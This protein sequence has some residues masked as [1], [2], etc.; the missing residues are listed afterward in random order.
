MPA[1]LTL[2]CAKRVCVSRSLWPLLSVGLFAINPLL[3]ALAEAS[4]TEDSTLT[5]GTVTVQGATDSNGPLSTSS[6][7]SSVDVLGADILEKM[8]VN[9]SWE[10]FSRAPGVMLTEFNQG[11]TS[12]KISF[13]GF[14]GEGEVNA[15]KL[16]IDGI[17][18]N[19]NDGNMPFMDMIF[20]MELDS[21]EVVRGTSDA[22]YGLN[23]IAGNVN[24]L[25]RTGGDYTKARIRYG[26]YN[27]QETQLAKGIETSNWT[28]N[29][30][31]AYQ[32]SD[33]YR[34]HAQADKFSMAGKW[35]Y[36]PD[37]NRY[38]IGLIA[39][40]YETEAQEPGYLSEEDAHQHPTMTN[41]Y[42][43]T[44]KGTRRMNQL[45]VHF[46]T[47]LSDTL[48]WAAKTYVNTF[49]DRRWTQYWRTS[50][51]QERDAYETQYGALTSLTWRP[52]V[53]WLY[54]FALEGGA[55][56]QQQHNKSERYR[57]KDRVRQAQ[58]R[59][60]QFDFDTYGAYVQ[61]EIK[62]FESLKI[63]P[64]Y[65]VDKIQGDFTNEMTGLDY[66]INDYGLIK[67]PKLSVVYSPWDVASVYANWGRTF[68]MGTGAA[69]YKI[70]P[71]DTDLAPSINEGWETGI[72]FTP[73]DWIDGRVAYWQQ[74][75]SG[76]VSRRL[77]DPSGES[78]N[79]GQTRRWGYDAQVNLHPNERT[80]LWMAYAWQYSKILQP[81]STLPN[82]KGQE[83]DHIPHHLYNAGVSY[84]A[85]PALQLTA[86]MNGQTNYYL[87][88]E[89]TRGTYG[90]YVLMNLGASYR[91]TESVSVDLQ[92]KNLTNRYY[93]YVWYDPD[94]AQASLHSPG[95]GRALYTGVSVDF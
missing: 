21:I 94:G 37:D 28:Q 34:D 56:M 80:D 95:D 31:F 45:S 90:G 9:Y 53:S 25:T 14:N 18:S 44:D 17:P 62:P 47:E 13:R 83:I 71:R 46:D 84:K 39:R 50:A 22:R 27:T 29:Y 66:A 43:A 38:R 89:N 36:T 65:R 6:V 92:L 75:A 49:D 74:K 41:S 24:M 67:Q 88:R 52:E 77:N 63:I 23:N 3:L 1:P 30:F 59:D 15:V 7:L 16:L 20:P 87:E 55:D 70:P 85:T 54:D 79:V 42:N 2:P 91:V 58:T 76:E 61:A 19:S 32:K 64:A 33:G 82:S 51:Q 26:S 60:Q 4:R 69:A 12:G 57:T 93:E 72:K 5:L 73:A 8:P 81:S 78:D 10:L 40:H 86:W 11:T 35:F 68:Q 48:A